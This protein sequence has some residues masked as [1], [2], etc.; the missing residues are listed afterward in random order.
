ML[1]ISSKAS[2]VWTLNNNRLDRFEACLG[3]SRLGNNPSSLV[4]LLS[5]MGS[6]RPSNRNSIREV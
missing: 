4:L 6:S 2:L 3:S 1:N 5:H